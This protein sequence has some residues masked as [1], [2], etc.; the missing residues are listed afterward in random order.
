[1]KHALL[2]MA[3]PVCLL[4][5]NVTNPGGAGGLTVATF[6]SPPAAPQT[7]QVFLFTD[8]SG[9]GVCSGGGSAYAI[10]TWNGSSFT[11]TSSAVGTGLGDPG[12]NS[13]VYR[14]GAGTS[15]P[16][17]ATQLSGPNFCPDAGST[18]SYACNLSPAIAAYVTGTF[19][20]F[21]A[22]TAN[23]GAASINFNSKGALTIK[24]MIGG[25]TTDLATGDIVV[26]QWVG[27]FYDGTNFQMATQLGTA[28]D[29]S[30]T[31]SLTNK[32]VD[33]ISPTTM[34]YLDATSS[35]QTQLNSKAP[36]ASPTFTGHITTEGVTATGAQG[37]GAFVFATN[38]TITGATV[39]GVTPTVF[40]R[41][42]PTSSVQ[43]QLNAKAPLASPTFTGHIT[44]EGVTATGATGSGNWVFD[45][46]ATLTG[47]T[48]DGITPTVFGYIDVTSSI[49]NQLNAKAPLASPTFTGTVT[50]P[51]SGTLQCLQ[52]N[53]S[54]VLSGTGSACGSGGGSGITNLVTGSGNPNTNGV[55]C[56]A[57]STSNLSL[58]QDTTTQYLWACTATNTWSLVLST[59]GSGQY[60]I[61]G[62]TG[63]APASPASGN[64][65]CYFDSSSN[66][67]VCLDSSGN[68]FTMVK[69]DTGASHNF[70]TG[71]TAGGLITKAQPAF[72]DISGTATSAQGGTGYSTYSDGQLLIGNGNTGNLNAATLT[73]GS[74][75]TITNGHGTITINATS[76]GTIA[77]TTGALKG[78]GSGNAV[79]VGGTGSYCV[80]ADG[81]T[82]ACATASNI[83]FQPTPQSVTNGSTTSVVVP[84]NTTLVDSSAAVPACVDGSGNGQVPGSWTNT[85][86]QMTIYFAP[87]AGFNGKCTAILLSTQFVYIGTY[88]GLPTPSSGNPLAL[89][90]DASAPGVCNAGGGSSLSI[91]GWTG[92]AWASV[93]ASGSTTAFSAITS[94]TNTQTLTIGS[95]GSLAPTSATVGTVSANQLNGT[96]L[97]GM[98]TGILHV[99]NGTGAAAGGLLVNADI[100]TGTIALTKLATQSADTVLMNNTGA[101][102]SPAAVAMPTSGTNGCAGATNALTYNTS[103][104]SLG[105][106]TI[107]NS[108]VVLSAIT[109]A[110]GSNTILNGN[111]PQTWNFAQTSNNQAALT[112]GE[113]SAATSGTLGN[114]FGLKVSGAAGSTAVP[115][116]VVSSLSG[117]QT[118]PTL[119]IAP[120]WNTSGVV[121]AALLV[122]VTNTASGTGSKLLDL[123][124]GGSSQFAVDS[125]GNVTAASVSSGASP[126]T[127]SGGTAGAFLNFEGTVPTTFA[128]TGYDGCY[129][130]STAHAYLCSMNAG[131]YKPMVIGPTSSTAADLPSFATTGGG[132]LQDSGIA[133]STVTTA[134]GTLTGGQLL[135]GAGSRGIQTTNLS[136]D[137]TTANSAVVTVVK[138]NGVSYGTNPS[139]GT[140]PVV[141]SSNTI[142]YE[143]LPLSS[144]ASIAAD[145]LLGNASGASAAPVAM[146]LTSCSSASNALTYNTSTHA[147]GC[148]TI[149]GSG[150]VTTTGSPAS[151]NLAKFSGATSVTNGDLTGDA[152]T[153]GT[154]AT[155]VAKVNGVSYAA[156]PSTDTVPVVTAANTATYTAVTNCGDSTHA[157]AYSTSTHTFSCQAIT[158]SA[159]AGGSSGQIQWNNSTA[160][161]G[162]ADWTFDGSHTITGG[163]SGL[164]NLSAMSAT[165]GF[166]PPSAAGA[167]PT[168]AGVCSFDSTANDWVCGNGSSTNHD[169][170]VTGSAPGAGLATFDGS[171]YS[172]TST[173]TSGTGNVLLASWLATPTAGGIGYG[174]STSQYGTTSAGTAKQLVASGG[175]SAPTFIDMIETHAVVPADCNGSTAGTGFSL[176]AS[177]APSPYCRTGTNVQT[178]Y[179]QYAASVQSAQF[180]YRLPSDWD[181]GTNPWI[182]INYTQN[183]AT[184]SQ[185]IA[186]SVA[187]ACNPTGTD[188]S[189]FNTAQTFTTT[190]TTTTAGTQYTQNL[191]LNSTSMT[192]CVAGGMMNFKI[193]STASQTA[194]A[195]LQMVTLSVPRLMVAQAN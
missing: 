105:C 112:I 134:A 40:S 48:V 113:S 169:A 65:L 68:A 185:V 44:T 9:T 139:S 21:K 15:I 106:N 157:L 79:A 140:V 150:T 152:T 56:T 100:T 129:A 13:V 91:C 14:N 186:F 25:I 34:G 115:L 96:A 101:S 84:F 156:S 1:M 170:F 111:N 119:Y 71:I 83:G 126:G 24:K 141:T 28:V 8:A 161:A 120:T 72:S 58:Y 88:S 151:G 12:S 163:A 64:V 148:N 159:S 57:P 74:N 51:I 6:G 144:I 145:N 32:T 143:V 182:S 98:T 114:Q 121:D 45:T 20:W 173:S 124:V 4:A 177:S 125:A 62:Q 107:S 123:Q 171:H 33:G 99:T 50:L 16:A 76:G 31:Q 166:K 109:A 108:S 195:N 104:H 43:T 176:P 17:T 3:L 138:V 172:L 67:Q 37:T 162:M 128:A 160:L 146:A 5:Q 155:T 158:G 11:A 41:L 116:G 77:A 181:S 42:D 164:L 39:D 78:D 153:S 89:L 80:H 142:T 165:A 194:V 168:T 130:D 93:A 23:T 133:A 95:G 53:S 187:V 2:L 132:V 131:T 26:G 63:S 193:A 47:A 86:T 147:F 179:L 82:G 117:S 70:V 90:T 110:T 183:A 136:G 178:G 87:S 127:I 60:T 18:D 191:Q 30:S 85:T 184:G 135:A 97:S 35:I 188:D 180:Q 19:Y 122:N 94:G 66:T 29:T 52:V 75:I 38:P 102:A 149:S 167:A 69:P 36:L 92:S 189:A 54:G 192:S 7:N 137:A 49:Q 175:T 174:T 61:T 118:L 190:T 55:T 10:C 103:T 73:A 81:T 27:G 46:G 22:N 59:N 154:L